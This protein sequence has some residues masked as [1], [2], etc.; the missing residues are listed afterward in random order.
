[1]AHPL[2][3]KQFLSICLSFVA[4]ACAEQAKP[5]NPAPANIAT[6]T[7]T[8]PRPDSAAA[9]TK[10]T[11]GAIAAF[12]PP[13]YAVLDSMAG[14]LNLDGQPDLLLILKKN[15][16]DSLSDVVE[17]PEKRPLLILVRG[18]NN[19]LQLAK[20][21]D[22][23]VLC[24]D[25]GGVM[26]DPYQALSIKDGYFSVEHYGG[27]NWRWTRVITYKYNQQEKDWFLH[28]DGSERFRADESENVKTKIRT[29]KDFGKLRFEAFDIYKEE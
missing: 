17:H 12:I 26:G 18:K 9:A 8:T 2:L 22:N 16:E 4:V 10:E 6:T 11:I 21:N 13:N 7:S 20:R 24:V 23:S 25:C 15:G 1:M 5:T 3:M 29:S 14:D 27:S 28:K 19:A